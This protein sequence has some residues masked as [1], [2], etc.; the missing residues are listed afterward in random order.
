[1]L[2]PP[3]MKAWRAVFTPGTAFFAVG[4]VGEHNLAAYKAA[5]A[6][7]AGVGSSLYAPGVD[8]PE[9]TR[10]ARAIVTCWREA[11]GA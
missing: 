8:L 2:G 4:G 10:R 9:L 5:G 7:G 1:M 3:V 11:R 6:A